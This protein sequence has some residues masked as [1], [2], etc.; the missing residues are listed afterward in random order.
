MGIDKVREQRARRALRRRGLDLEKSR[1]R[2]PQARGFG[3]YRI[4]DPEARR[5]VAGGGV[6]EFSLSLDTVEAWL[7]RP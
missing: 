1:R 2:D 6:G 3:R 4:I 5:V 7:A